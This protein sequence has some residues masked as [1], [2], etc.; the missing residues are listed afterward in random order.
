MRKIPLI[1]SVKFQLSPGYSL[2]QKS[3][4]YGGKSSFLLIIA[5]MHLVLFDR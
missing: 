4:S 1:K 5:L 2:F 3:I